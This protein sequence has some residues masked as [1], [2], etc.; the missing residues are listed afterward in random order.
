MN[1]SKIAF[2][3]LGGVAAG[4]LIGILFAPHK[5]SKT[6]KKIIGKGKDFSEEIKGTLGGIFEN[7]TDKLD[8]LL[9]EVKEVSI[10]K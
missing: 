6:R 9:S 3:V 10:P 7:V 2:G 4:A 1:S 8:N 5:G